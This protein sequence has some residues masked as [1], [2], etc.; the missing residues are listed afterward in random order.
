[1]NSILTTIASSV[2]FIDETTKL[3][4]LP[5]VA[6][7]ARGEDV[8][9]YTNDVAS[10][11]MCVNANMGGEMM[12]EQIESANPGAVAVLPIKGVI[13]KADQPCGPNGTETFMENLKALNEDELKGIFDGVLM[14]GQIDAILAR[15]DKLVEH[16]E[17]MIAE[18]GEQNV[19]FEEY[20]RATN[21]F[22]SLGGLQYAGAWPR[23]FKDG[24]ALLRATG[25]V[26]V[27]LLASDLY[28]RRIPWT[29]LLIVA[30]AIGLL[31]AG[32]GDLTGF[33]HYTI[34]VVESMRAYPEAFSQSDN[35]WA[36]ALFLLGV[37]CAGVSLSAY[38]TTTLSPATYRRGPA[39]M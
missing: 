30:F 11:P 8:N 2:W 31:Y 27:A 38:A 17:N 13:T 19:M 22:E 37:A 16:V 23:S 9:F 26:V 6:R 39:W 35:A 36:P 18:K 14:G 5:F 1:M 4:A 12:Q 10:T 7:L 21:V 33:A 25:V 24:E 29:V 28:Q 15:R 34:H 3:A 20:A 32:G